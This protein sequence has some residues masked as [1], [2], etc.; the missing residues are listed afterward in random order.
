[1]TQDNY[2]K[3]NQSTDAVRQNSDN[4]DTT[5]QTRKAGEETKRN[6]E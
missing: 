5:E 6:N 1:M 3:T 2:G 4:Q